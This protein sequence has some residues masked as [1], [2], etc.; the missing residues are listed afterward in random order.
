MKKPMQ[1][2]EDD[3]FYV[4]NPEGLKI[5]TEYDSAEIMSQGTTLRIRTVTRNNVQV[6]VQKPDGFVNVS[7]LNIKPRELQRHC[8]PERRSSPNS[9]YPDN[10]SPERQDELLEE[11]NFEC[12]FRKTD[13]S[14]KVRNLMM[15]ATGIKLEFVASNF[16][17]TK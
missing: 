6:S 3:L 15:R 9:S 10:I 8:A 14:Q 12:T 1:L 17:N 13:T 2:K 4:K 7:L 11:A 5:S 16:F